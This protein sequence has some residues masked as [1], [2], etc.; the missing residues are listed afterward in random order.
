MVVGHIDLL[1]LVNENRFYRNGAIFKFAADTR[2]LS[3]VPK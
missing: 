1:S 3:V 2:G